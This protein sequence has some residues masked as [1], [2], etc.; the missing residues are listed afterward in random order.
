VQ[1]K[2]GKRLWIPIHRDLK[3]VLTTIEPREGKKNDNVGYT[4]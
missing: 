4:G 2:T 3:Q 1:N